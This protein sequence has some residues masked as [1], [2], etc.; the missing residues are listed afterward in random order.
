MALKHGTYVAE[1]LVKFNIRLLTDKFKIMTNPVVKSFMR[2]YLIAAIAL[3]FNTSCLCQSD[4]KPASAKKET[5]LPRSIKSKQTSV[6]GGGKDAD[7]LSRKII[8]AF[9]K[10]DVSGYLS[11]IKGKDEED[12]KKYFKIIREGLESDGLSD[13]SKMQFSRVTYTKDKNGDDLSY[14]RIEFEYGKNFSGAM[15]STYAVKHEGRYY[16]GHAFYNGGMRRN[17]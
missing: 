10:N 14:F 15:G 5:T 3:L 13:W 7:E 1:T 12:S 11:L 9:K 2:L 17:Y 4:K 8:N 6:E 16:L